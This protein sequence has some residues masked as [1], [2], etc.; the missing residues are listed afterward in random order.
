MA[1]V[2]IAGPMRGIKYFNFPAFDAAEI[3]LTKQGFDVISPAKLDRAAGF[4]PETLGNDY[5]WLDLQKI[6]FELSDAVKRDADALTK[7]DAIYLLDGWQRSKGATAEKAIAEWLGL[8]VMYQTVEGVLQEA[9][10]ITSGDR[11]ASYGPPDQDFKRTAAMWSAIK[12]V[13]FTARE[14]AMFMVCLKLSRETHQ[15]KR[16]NWV[17]IAGYAKCGS[18]CT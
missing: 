6:G 1:T 3:E 18:E 13:E 9:I 16:D 10:R 2:Y 7:S 11:Q 8:T 14:V 5:D 12:G 15:N 17:D 4:D